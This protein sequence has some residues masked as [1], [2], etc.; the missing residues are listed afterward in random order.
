MLQNTFDDK[1]TLVQV[2]PWCHQAA[3]HYLS[4]YWYG[5]MSPCGIIRSQGINWARPL[6]NTVLTTRL[7]ILSSR[8]CSNRILLLHMNSNISW[9]F[10]HFNLSW[11]SNS[12]S[13]IQI[14][15]NCIYNAD[16]PQR[17]RKTASIMQISHRE[18]ENGII[19][20][21]HNDLIRQVTEQM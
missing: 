8:F 17:N 19:G 16:K 20:I 6:A 14:S 11:S 15:L 10:E 1:S 18:I 7:N 13:I 2:M 3:G 21:H 12:K 4:Q 9:H 5:S